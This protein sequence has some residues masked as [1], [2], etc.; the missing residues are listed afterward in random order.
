MVILILSPILTAFVVSIPVFF[1]NL[2]EV[3]SGRKTWVGYCSGSQNH[4]PTLKK[5]ILSPASLYP[6]NIP[7]KK[8]DE[9]NIVY[10]KNYRL[11]NDLE[12][13]GKAWKDIGKS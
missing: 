7:D 9:L 10:A 8:K 4:L 5:G 3:M 11:L 2:F 6:E 13:V 1:R 12:I